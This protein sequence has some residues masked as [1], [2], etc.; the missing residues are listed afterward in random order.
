[1]PKKINKPKSIPAKSS[2]INILLL[3]VIILPFLLSIS[4]VFLGHLPFWYD[5]ARDLLLAWD[6]LRKP[7][8]I[9]PP[10]GI[11]GIFYGPY[12]IWILSMGL[13]ISKD[14]RLVVFL[15]LTL[16]YF[17]ILP[18]LLLKLGN[19]L[20]DK[21]TSIIVWLLFVLS[22]MGYTNQIWNPHP[23]PLIFFAIVLMVT[24]IKFSLFDK[25]ILASVF[26]LGLLQGLLLNFHISFGLGIF[27]ASL[28]FFLIHCAN[29]IGRLKEKTKV[30]IEWFIRL[31]L[32][33]AG[34]VIMFL[35]TL[36]FETRHGFNQIKALLFTLNQT[37]V[38][39]QAIVG[40]VGLNRQQILAAFSE[41]LTTL[42]QLPQWISLIGSFFVIG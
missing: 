9:G 35:P 28:F 34:I 4:S 36:F 2:I 6:N 13:A 19:R 27:L 24:K 14:P 20:F 15:V 40:Q 10:T 39:H 25:K 17:L 30:L 37:V 41:R 23:A 18:L 8:L 32:Y 16:P 3:G 7:T 33:M 31:C 21:T 5:P 22:F 11:P 26:I 42:L 1:M 29:D 38:R 12:W